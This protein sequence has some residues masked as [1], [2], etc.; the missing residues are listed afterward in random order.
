MT[1]Q[2]FQNHS[3]K[4]GKY[5][6]PILTLT[7]VLTSFT[8]MTYATIVT[9]AVPNVMG[10]FGVGQDKAQLVATGFYISMT[11]SQL[12]CAWLLLAVGHYYTF[13]VSILFFLFA[14]FIGALSNDFTFIVISRI[15]QGFSAGILMSQ[16]MIAVV[17]AYPISRRGYALS[18]FTIGGVLAIGIGPVLGGIIIEWLSW[19]EI[20]LIPIPLLII[21]FSLGLIVMPKIINFKIP[22]F[23]WFGLIFLIISLYC[24]MTIFADGQRQGWFSDYVMALLF[25]GIFSSL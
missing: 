15:M 9:V 4:F 3:K 21:T 6:L 7:I 2:I 5:Y 24:F 20:F 14:C 22:K 18:M 23:D 11:V 25:I 19:R 10:A 13:T 1:S 17:Q 12:I 16:T 8:M